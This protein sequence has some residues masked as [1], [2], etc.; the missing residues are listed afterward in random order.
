MLKIKALLLVVQ[1]TQNL[2]A[3]NCW[4][5]QGS[6]CSH[7]IGEKSNILGVWVSV[8]KWF[9]H[10]LKITAVVDNSDNSDNLPA[11]SWTI[12]CPFLEP[13]Q[14]EFLTFFDVLR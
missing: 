1:K 13:C 7:E 6:P 9:T 4:K 2:T 14:A 8:Q 3:E 11:E 10:G 5:H 12:T